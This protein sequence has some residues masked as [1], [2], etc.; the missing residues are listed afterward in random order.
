[1]DPNEN[2]Q[3]SPEPDTV[4]STTK[5]REPEP[6]Q[7]VTKNPKKVEAGKKGALVRKLRNANRASSSAA[8]ANTK[9]QCASSTAACANSKC[10]SVDS[11][12]ECATNK[13]QYAKSI[14]VLGIGIGV[15]LLCERFVFSKHT[16]DIQLKPR[17]TVQYMR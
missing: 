4:R 15:G 12:T 16:E 8:C 11:T 3:T 17:N 14:I 2:N 7:R 1:M 6:L 10:Q 5:S 9:S 13:S